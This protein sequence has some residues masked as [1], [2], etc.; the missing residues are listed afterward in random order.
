MTPEQQKLA[1]AGRLDARCLDCG[2]GMAVTAHCY[3][4]GSA[5]L[6]LVP[7]RSGEPCL[8][9]GRTG[10][11]GGV[12]KRSGLGGFSN[13]GAAT[14]AGV[15]SEATVPVTAPPAPETAVQTAMAL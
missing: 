13:A 6:E 2:A 4:C 5:N 9:S 11:V 14:G 7:H 3:L 12:P 15:V 1:Q 10:R 8:A